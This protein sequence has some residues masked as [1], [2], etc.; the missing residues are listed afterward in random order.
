MNEMRPPKRATF[1]REKISDICQSVRV[2]VSE[3]E[4]SQQKLDQ[5]E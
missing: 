5:L 4:I 2:I 3:M 1:V